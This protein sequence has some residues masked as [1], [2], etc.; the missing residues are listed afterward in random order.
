[1]R[2]GLVGMAGQDLG[3]AS[4]GLWDA[5]LTDCRRSGAGVHV[6]GLVGFGLGELAFNGWSGDPNWVI[7]DDPTWEDNYPRLAWEGAEG[8][9]VPETR[10]WATF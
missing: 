1:M 9:T 6:T 8:I 2:G 3:S 10:E 7:P 5:D 4:N